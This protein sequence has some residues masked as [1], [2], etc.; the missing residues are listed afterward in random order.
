MQSDQRYIAL[1]EKYRELRRNE[2]N[3]ELSEKVLKAAQVLRN[4]GKVSEEAIEVVRYL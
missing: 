3:R 1:V 4:S 2:S